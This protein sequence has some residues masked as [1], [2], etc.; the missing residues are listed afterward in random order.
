MTLNHFYIQKEIVQ[1]YYKRKM[2]TIMLEKY[3]MLVIIIYMSYKKNIL[4][5]CIDFEY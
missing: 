1:M 4:H 2:T 3:L 5:T